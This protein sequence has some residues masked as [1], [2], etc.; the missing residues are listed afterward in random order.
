MQSFFLFSSS[1]A[2]GHMT[3]QNVAILLKKAALNVGFNPEVISPHTLRHSFASH[4]LE[5][6]EITGDS[7][8]TWPC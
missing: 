6:G 2:L 8:I 1:P 4:L 5:G 3:R 7:R